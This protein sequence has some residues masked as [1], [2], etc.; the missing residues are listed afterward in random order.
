ML[1][2]REGGDVEDG[3]QCRDGVGDVRCW[4]SRH[5]IT[6]I[7]IWRA[8]TFFAALIVFKGFEVVIY[9]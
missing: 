9:C 3:A 6:N 4:K 5:E 8:E 7:D 2:K 1:F